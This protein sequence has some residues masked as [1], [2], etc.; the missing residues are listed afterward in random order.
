M[1]VYCGTCYNMRIKYMFSAELAILLVINAFLCPFRCIFS[2]EP[3]KIWVF[4]SCSVSKSSKQEFSGC[5]PHPPI[6]FLIK[7]IL[8]IYNKYF[9]NL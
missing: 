8:L 2:A 3:V 9:L 1:H 7:M 4:N 5:V 6:I